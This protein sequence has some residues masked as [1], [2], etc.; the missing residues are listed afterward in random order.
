MSSLKSNWH[1]GSSG[2]GNGL[3]PVRRQAIIWSNV[4]MFNWRKYAL[5]EHKWACFYTRWIIYC[6][7]PS[8]AR[9]QQYYDH[10]SYN[11]HQKN[12]LA[13]D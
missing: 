4:G 12:L 1:H 13:Q 2:S 10:S 8:L 7:L 3:A 9:I 6:A 11:M 5:S